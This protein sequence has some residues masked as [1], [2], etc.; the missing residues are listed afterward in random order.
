MTNIDYKEKPATSVSR[1]F[2]FCSFLLKTIDEMNVAKKQKKKLVKEKI[3]TQWKQK[4]E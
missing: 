3:I 1:I 4:K 2:F